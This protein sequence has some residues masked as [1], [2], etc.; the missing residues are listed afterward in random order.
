MYVSR[1]ALE[2]LKLINGYFG[3]FLFPQSTHP[4]CL[5]VRTATGNR[6]RNILI[7]VA[8]GCAVLVDIV[9]WLYQIDAL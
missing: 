4:Y 8:R 5:R 1:A 6:S 9:E 7:S 3:G 2:I